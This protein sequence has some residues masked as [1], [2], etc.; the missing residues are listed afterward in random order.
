MLLL[1]ACTAGPPPDPIEAQVAAPDILF[2]TLDTLRA[3]RLGAYGDPL[4]RTPHLDGL[5]AE[6]ALF[7][8][9]I[10]PVPLTLPAHASMFTGLYPNEHGLRDN[11]GFALDTGHALVA[12]EL[13]TAGYS[14]GAFVS[15]YVLHHSL[16]LDRGFEVYDDEVEGERPASATVDAALAWWGEAQGP[17]MMWV[18]LFDAHRPYEGKGGDPYR[19]EV[20]ALDV[21]VGRLLEATDGSTLVVVAGDHGENLWDAGEL[22]HGMVLTRSVL[23]VP[24]IVRPPGGLEGQSSPPARLIERPSEWLPVPEIDDSPFDLTP[25]PDAPRAARVVEGPVSLVALAATLR[26]YAGLST[27]PGLRAA[28]E[29]ASPSGPVFAESL[30]P[31]FHYGWAPDFY[32]REGDIVL[33][34]DGAFDDPTDP[35]WLLATAQQPTGLRAFVASHA[36]L[37][38]GPDST[39]PEVLRGLEALGY[40]TRRVL[41]HQDWETLP[42]AADRMALLHRVFIAQ[43]RMAS[44]PAFA[45][46]ELEEA[47][48]QD[49][50]L[51]DAWFSLASL[52]VN[53]LDRRGA[54]EAL[55]EVLKRV[56]DHRNA[57]SM[58]LALAR[59]LQDPELELQV[60]E[61]TAA[62]TGELQAHRL[63]AESLV[64]LGR[65]PT[66]AALAGLLVDPRDC[67]LN[68]L[69]AAARLESDPAGALEHLGRMGDCPPSGRHRME[70]ACQLALG[71]PE[72]ALAAYRE[73]LSH[74]PD[75]VEA[76]G[77]E[78]DLLVQLGRCEEALPLL[79]KLYT[80]QRRPEV[81]ATYRACGGTGF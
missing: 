25:V 33:R 69:V 24:L 58:K 53:E 2:I 42:R 78:A 73:Q 75:D 60:A 68:G 11:S 21:A 20:A 66:D 37:G 17:R 72:D 52:R 77:A 23:R 47:L 32:G 16:G 48:S 27:A 5:A 1:L 36:V 65:D 35:W 26:E 61:Q 13:S 29:G 74:T 41:T 9:A 28:V 79:E 54:I 49:P 8:D 44:D 40:T 18:H 81:L 50:G 62:A 51:V 31:L 71:K 19:G 3:D 10:T 56:P 15:A 46:T 6:G 80:R 22:E 55:D 43:G 39:A 4:A 12:E 64:K 63:V 76:L 38:Q 67:T 57:L 7:R 45:R 34:G 14:T 70:G 59:A 30:Y